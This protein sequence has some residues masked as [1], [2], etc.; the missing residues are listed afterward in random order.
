ML[1]MVSKFAQVNPWELTPEEFSQGQDIYWRGDEVMEPR[2]SLR[3]E[4]IYF[5]KDRE[6]AK[7]Y[8]ETFPA[9][10]EVH[11]PFDAQKGN[12]QELLSAAQRVADRA[13]SLFVQKKGPYPDWQYALWDVLEDSYT[14]ALKNGDP[15]PILRALGQVGT[16]FG[17]EK[18]GQIL[19]EAGYDGLAMDYGHGPVLAAIDPKQ[20][21]THKRHVLK[22]I[23]DGKDVPER[24][25][26]LYGI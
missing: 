25:R 3:N 2:H 8:G 16:K 24:I 22:A 21:W 5:A 12:I 1:T 7:E 4:G 11:R 15:A 14:H 9:T 26:K 10:L 18:F 20:V 6:Y 17:S 19:L 13:E 23:E